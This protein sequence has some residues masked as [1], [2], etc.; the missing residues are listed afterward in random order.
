MKIL[1]DC[2]N[3]PI[4]KNLVRVCNKARPIEIDENIKIPIKFF[5]FSSFKFIILS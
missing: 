4:N 3:N 5:Y 1:N 2:A